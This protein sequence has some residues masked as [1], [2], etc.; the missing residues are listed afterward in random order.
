MNKPFALIADVDD[1]LLGND[2]ALEEFVA[3]L[4]GVRR[5]LA[6]VY[7]SGRMVDSLANVI[8]ATTLPDP[9]FIIAGVGSEIRRYP[10]PGRFCSSGTTGCRRG[11][12]PTGCGTC[13]C[14]RPTWCPSLT[15]PSR[16]S[17]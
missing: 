12:M 7:A 15:T 13:S 8:R 3:Y 14:P 5:E 2:L 1:T 4:H 17:R 16:P 6:L 9:E 10:E 11:G